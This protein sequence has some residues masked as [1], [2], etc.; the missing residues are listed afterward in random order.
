MAASPQELA[1][2]AALLTILIAATVWIILHGACSCFKRCKPPNDAQST[3]S[4]AAIA[5]FGGAAI[6]STLVLI[7][8]AAA[9][10]NPMLARW[11]ELGTALAL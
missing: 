5:L 1:S 7:H 11:L 4:F 8:L 3:A 6:A 10:Q 9:G 2:A